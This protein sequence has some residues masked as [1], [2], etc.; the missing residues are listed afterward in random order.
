MNRC[1]SPQ[2]P[3]LTGPVTVTL[4]P[5]TQARKVAQKQPEPFPPPT[6]ALCNETK[7]STRSPGWGE[8][9]VLRAQAPG[10]Q[11]L[12]LQNLKPTRKLLEQYHNDKPNC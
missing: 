8:G 5:L 3:Y 12:I 10:S 2:G 6:K 4:S 11:C 9:A 1:L 7:P